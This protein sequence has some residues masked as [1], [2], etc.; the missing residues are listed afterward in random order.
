LPS[1]DHR[2]PT[3]GIELPVLGIGAANVGATGI[4]SAFAVT[5]LMPGAYW[6][7]DNSIRVNGLEGNSSALRVEGQDAT[8]TVTLALISQ[9]EPSVEAVQEFAI[10]T[11]N[12]AAEFGQAG[13]GLFNV[14]IKSG[15]NQFHG[16]G[17]D[18]F[19]NEALNA[20]EPFTNDGDG[21]L[22]RPRQ[23]RN[24]YGASL[25]GP[26]EIPNCIT[27]TTRPSSL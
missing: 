15:T 4:R 19:V 23:R 17:Y 18:Y 16:S 26:V 5:Q 6:N 13:G 9:N 1:P 27:A 24:D 22:L 10:Q 8:N 20:G 25:G 21:H 14:T 3:S 11:S 2:S 12:Y 7:P